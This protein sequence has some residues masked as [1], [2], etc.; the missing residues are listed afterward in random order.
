MAELQPSLAPCKVGS[1]PKRHPNVALLNSR[2]LVYSFYMYDILKRLLW[3]DLILKEGK[4][5]F[6]VTKIEYKFV[7]KRILFGCLLADFNT[8]LHACIHTNNYVCTTL[9][10]T[11]CMSDTLIDPQRL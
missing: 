3:V 8:V 10:I 1:G 9:K 11:P 6:L 4:N 7:F 5:L 2:V